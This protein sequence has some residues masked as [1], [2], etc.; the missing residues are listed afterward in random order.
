MEQKYEPEQAIVNIGD[1][2]DSFYIIKEG[3]ISIRKDGVEIKVLV[4]GE[5]FGESG[6]LLG[7]QK[8]TMSCIASEETRCLALGREVL[9]QLLGDQVEN[10][11]YR[12]MSK[13]AI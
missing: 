5:S 7:N 10:I 3:K 12:N 2:A 6:L 8:R 9:T 11:L 4:K 1:P 13:W